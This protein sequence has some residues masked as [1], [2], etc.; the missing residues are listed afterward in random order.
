MAWILRGTVGYIWLGFRVG[1]SI[2]WRSAW[3]THPQHFSQNFDFHFCDGIVFFQK[4]SIFF[5]F[6]SLFMPQRTVLDYSESDP[7]RSPHYERAYRTQV[8]SLNLTS[9]LHLSTP[10]LHPLTR[11]RAKF[12]PK[13]QGFMTTH[14]INKMNKVD[15]LTSEFQF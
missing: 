6:F 12:T 9:K 3:I 4:F 5:R 11:P 14:E 8:Q 13:P 2:M 7:A 10:R 15:M 1:S